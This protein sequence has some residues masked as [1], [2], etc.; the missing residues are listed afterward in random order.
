MAVE[1]PSDLI[2]DVARAADPASVR[3]LEARLNTGKSA[4]ATASATEITGAGTRLSRE[5]SGKDVTEIGKKF[6]AVLLTTMIEDMMTETGE[7]YFGGGFAGDVW[8]S[9]MAEQ[10]AAQ[11]A[12]T[13]NLGFASSIADYVVRQGE[14]V[15]PVRGVNDRELES[16]K[17]RL[18][19]AARRGTQEISRDFIRDVMSL[20]D[21]GTGNWQTTGKTET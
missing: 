2:L 18:L 11:V 17:A 7:S 20:D 14:T 13:G 10:I 9:M 5:A 1:F 12:E 4:E 8:K 6:E 3:R 16:D 21:S 15:E 19:D